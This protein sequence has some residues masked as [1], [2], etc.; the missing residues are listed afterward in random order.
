MKVYK[1]SLKDKLYLWLQENNIKRYA[2]LYPK[3]EQHQLK[4]F[5]EN[6]IRL[7]I[8]FDRYIKNYVEMLIFEY[9]SQV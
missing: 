8:D 1:L 3:V 7:P 9:E 2:Y 4:W 6:G 5:N